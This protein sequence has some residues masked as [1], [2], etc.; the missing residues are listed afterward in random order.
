MDKMPSH[1]EMTAIVQALTFLYM[2]ALPDAE[3]MKRW[4]TAGRDDREYCR[5]MDDVAGLMQG[6]LEV[7][8]RSKSSS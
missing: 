8:Y 6:I 4:E 7:A 5:T 2:A 3:R 1:G